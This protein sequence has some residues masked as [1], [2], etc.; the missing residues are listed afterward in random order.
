[1]DKTTV[2]NI[3][4]I[5]RKRKRIK[6]LIVKVVNEKTMINENESTENK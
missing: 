4:K 6:G 5:R 3:R 1:M 2:H